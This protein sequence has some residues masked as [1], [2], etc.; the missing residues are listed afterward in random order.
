MPALSSLREEIRMLNVT[1]KKKKK[2]HEHKEQG[3]TQHEAPRC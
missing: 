1:E 3:K 2:K